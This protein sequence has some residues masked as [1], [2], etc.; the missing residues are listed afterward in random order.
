MTEGR[1]SKRVFE[2]TE[3]AMELIACIDELRVLADTEKE[4]EKNNN[5]SKRG[6]R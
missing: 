4:R 6:L 3:A 5:K 2:S 1:A